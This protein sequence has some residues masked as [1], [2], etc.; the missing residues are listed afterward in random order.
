MPIWRIAASTTALISVQI[1]YAVQFALVT[2]Q[3]AM[4]GVPTAAIPFV[5]AAGPIAGLIVQPLAGVTSD[6]STNRWGRR[7]PF[8]LVGS[9]LTVLGMLLLVCASSWPGGALLLTI[10]GLYVMNFAINIMQGP[11]RALIADTVPESQQQFANSMATLMMGGANLFAYG[12]GSQDLVSVFPFF[13]SNFIALFSIGLIFV[14]L[15][16]TPT[17]IFAEEKALTDDH[18]PK[19]KFLVFFKKILVAMRTMPRPLLRV[20]VLYFFCWCAFQPFQLYITDFFGRDVYGG[21]PNASKGSHSR[22]EYEEGVRMGSLALMTMSGISLL[23][24]PVQTPSLKAFGI[25]PN[26]FVSESIAAICFILPLFL[27]TPAEA[28]IYTS[29]VGVNFVT[30]NSIPFALLRACVSPEESGVFMGVMN[31]YAVVGM[32]IS[33]FLAGS[34][35][36]PVFNTTAAAIATGGFF[37]VIAAAMVFLI[38]PGDYVAS[39]EFEE[40]QPL[41]GSHPVK[42]DGES[43]SGGHP[44]KEDSQ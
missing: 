13:G 19:V 16:V 24:S 30:F 28:F 40:R 5:W 25:R 38:R 11:A 10:L 12:M 42:E 23:F 6:S 3:L 7:R 43:L 31:V 17:L 9:I 15:G 14:V 20:C 8:I 36:M 18:K 41:A 29:F 32:L 1:S 26:W 33:S 39:H 21:D 4:L 22:K 2:P 34:L 37:A 44:V 35:F 27:Q